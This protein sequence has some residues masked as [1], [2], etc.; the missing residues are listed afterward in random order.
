MF[1]IKE[2]MKSEY[3]PAENNESK[4][5]AY[6]YRIFTIFIKVIGMMI[7]DYFKKFF[8][9]CEEREKIA[10]QLAL[11]TGIFFFCKFK[12]IQIFNWKKIISRRWKWLR[13]SAL[14]SI[15]C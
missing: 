6:K 13:S 5:K 1:D 15:S 12:Q 4:P 10:N 9:K 8:K 11:V 3:N 14:L 7:S 2:I